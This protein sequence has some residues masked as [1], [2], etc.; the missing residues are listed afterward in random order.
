MGLLQADD[1][2][3]EKRMEDFID[4]KM[5]V[6]KDRDDVVENKATSKAKSEEDQLYHIEDVAK[7]ENQIDESISG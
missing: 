1:K 6:V 5:G 4:E 7:N 2:V 3:H